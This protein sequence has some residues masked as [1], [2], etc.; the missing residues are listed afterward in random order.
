MIPKY[1]TCMI[2]EIV[3]SI[4]K[5]KNGRIIV[6]FQI[7]CLLKRSKHFK[8]C[9]LEIFKYLFDRSFNEEKGEDLIKN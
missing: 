5:K 1:L 3:M 4:N 2:N 6:S 8:K 9:I 7:N